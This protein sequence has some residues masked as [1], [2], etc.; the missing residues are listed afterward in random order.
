MNKKT[1]IEL[2]NEY[3]NLL[4]LMDLDE[5][6]EEYLHLKP[7]LKMFFIN[8][9]NIWLSKYDKITDEERLKLVN[10]DKKITLAYFNIDGKLKDYLCLETLYI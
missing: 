8:L 7:T 4:Y 5:E 1:I 2:E 10:M 9:K 3:K 6:S